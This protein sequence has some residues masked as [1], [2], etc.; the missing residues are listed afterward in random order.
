MPKVSKEHLEARRRG[1]L[2]A[3]FRCFVRNGLHATTV[4]DICRAANLSPGALYSYFESKRDIIAALALDS[5]RRLVEFFASGRPAA[6]GHRLAQLLEVLEQP[7]AAE[8]MRLDIV[9][10]GEALRD[11][12]LQTIVVEGTERSIQALAAETGSDADA[13]ARAR[14][15]VALFDGLALQKT[16]DPELELEP[17]L[18]A[19]PGMLG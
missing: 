2:N 6:P 12:E 4:R 19:L 16:L 18:A 3:A 1:I 10:W 8:R 15:L 9:L 17:V 7:T 14:A 11:P 13:L 5:R